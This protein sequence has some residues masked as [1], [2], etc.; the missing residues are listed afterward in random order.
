MIDPA[1]K[2]SSVVLLFGCLI[3]RHC[4]AYDIVIPLG[5]RGSKEYRQSKISVSFD[6]ALFAAKNTGISVFIGIFVAVNRY[7]VKFN[8]DSV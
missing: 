8:T 3:D 2:I 5:S 4:L 7:A 1:L 6:W